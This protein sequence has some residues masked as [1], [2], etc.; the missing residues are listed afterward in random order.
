MKLW[1]VA[2]RTGKTNRLHTGFAPQQRG[3][4]YRKAPATRIIQ[5]RYG[6]YDVNNEQTEA[7]GPLKRITGARAALP[8]N[9]PR[10]EFIGSLKE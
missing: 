6:D 3:Y 1:K 4:P 10:S 2:G 5:T 9:C 7:P 8:Q